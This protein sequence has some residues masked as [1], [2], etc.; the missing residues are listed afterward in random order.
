MD[1]LASVASRSN[2]SVARIAAWRIQLY[3]VLP[4]AGGFP[5][6]VNQKNGQ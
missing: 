3:G 6:A 5:T 1:K 2:E 4:Q